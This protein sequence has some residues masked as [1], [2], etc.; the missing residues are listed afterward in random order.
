M[1]L[2]WRNMR[3]RH[4]A[5]PAGAPASA[6]RHA[7][8]KHRA[9][10]RQ[11]SEQQIR[12]LQACPVVLRVGP[13][14]AMG[15]VVIV[16]AGLVPGVPL[17]RQDPF[18]AMNMRSI[19]LYTRVPTEDRSGVPWERVWNRWQ[20]RVPEGERVTVVYGH[21]SKR[22]LNVKKYSKGLDSGCVN[23]DRLTALVVEG[24]G[25]QGY[26]SVQRRKKGKKG[27]KE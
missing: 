4:A 18:M 9:L 17:E 8:D 26:V 10:A 5:P 20:K 27:K 6:S 3:A 21:D 16:H 15:E 23:G 24:G 25:R 1:L 13:V 7:D 22:G 2:A 19:D 11:F 14:P 12:W